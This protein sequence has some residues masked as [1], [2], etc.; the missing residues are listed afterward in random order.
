MSVGEDRILKYV[1]SL[2]LIGSGLVVF[3]ASVLLSVYNKSISQP[4]AVTLPPSLANHAIRTA[5]YGEEAVDEVAQ[6]HSK[7]FPLISGGVGIYGSQDEA[8]L[9][10]TGTILN[11]TA[12][13]MVRTM[14]EKIGQNDTP[15]Q[16]VGVID[17]N[18]HSVQELSGLGQRHFYFKAGPLVIWLAADPSLAEEALYDAM[19]FYP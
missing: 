17:H 13:G 9:W 6:L 1:G 12:S 8:T 14:E 10:V 18:G 19:E 2:V 15:F 7:G 11:A 5:V 16:T 3:A 4:K